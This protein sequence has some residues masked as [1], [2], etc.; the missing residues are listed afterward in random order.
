MRYCFLFDECLTPALVGIAEARDHDA[1]HAGHRGLL[2]APDTPVVRYC[3][4][5]DVIVVTNN[6]KDDLRLYSQELLHAGLI[7]ILPSVDAV[8]QQELFGTVLDWLGSRHDL[9]NRAV[10][11]DAAGQVHS[12]DWAADGG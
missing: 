3:V 6:R 11:V 12:F 9:T 10:E 4:E 2:S 5:R 7:I 8:R 1:A